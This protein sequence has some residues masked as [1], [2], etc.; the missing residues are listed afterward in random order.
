M[1]STA[2]AR[3]RPVGPS[4]R[5]A[6][7]G[8][9]LRVDAAMADAGFEDRQFPDGRVLR[10]CSR[11]AGSTISAIGRELGIT[12]QGAGKVVGRLRDR[13]Y[14]SVA[15]SEASGREKSVTVTPRGAEYLGAQ[16]HATQTID[17]QL[18]AELGEAGL[19]ALFQLLD[20]LDQGE[21]VR[22]A[23]YLQRSA[24]FVGSAEQGSSPSG[25]GDVGS[26]PCS[27]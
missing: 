22:L 13:G 15:D 18:R 5:R 19:S 9:Q 24:A 16:R 10:Q 4:L 3:Q 8:Y 7:L 12:R 14:V 20:V 17:S 11:P 2:P 1:D 21:Q 26:S 27:E 6:W 23:T 25:T